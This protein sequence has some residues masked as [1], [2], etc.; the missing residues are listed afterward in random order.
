MLSKCCFCI[1]LRPATLILSAI[2]I[3]ANFTSAW[4]FSDYNSTKYSSIYSFISTYHFGVSMICLFGFVGVL[5]NKIN[6]IRIFAYYFWY[7]VILGFA[8][9]ILFSV[10]AFHLD[11]DIC[12]ELIGQ[13][14]IDVDLE[15]CMDL[16][17]KTAAWMVVL[18][19]LTCLVELH[20]CLAVWAYYQQLRAECLS[21]RPDIYYSAVPAY[22]VSPPSYD[23]II[24][25]GNSSDNPKENAKH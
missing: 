10:L 6:Y 1:G 11:R 7:K 12:E 16:Y 22:V 24:N 17:V 19:G 21:G 18:L 8:L 20:F 5:K 15:T 23:V 3:I 9:S 25:P 4:Q 14:E 13:H 2:G